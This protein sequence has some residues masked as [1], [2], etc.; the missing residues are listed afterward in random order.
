[1]VKEAQ[2]AEKRAKNDYNRGAF[3]VSLLKR[4]GEIVH[5]GSKWENGA[6][7]LF[8]R[9]CELREDKD[10][11]PISAR[12]PYA[13]AALLAP[14]ELHNSEF[15]DGFSP[16]DLIKKELE[17]VLEQQVT[18][19]DLRNELRMLC[20]TYLLGL[21]TSVYHSQCPSLQDRPKWEDFV[22]LFLTAAFIERDRSQGEG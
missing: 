13:L 6:L 19:K 20:E 8:S 2:I 5:W 14:H 17:H 9:Y 7:R 4:G 11:S 15:V 10:N 22:K 21:K 1:M 18:G 16:E 12:F 3:A